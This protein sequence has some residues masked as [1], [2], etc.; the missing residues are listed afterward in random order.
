MPSTSD[1]SSPF[2]PTRLGP[3][4]ICIRPS[5]LRSIRM[6]ASTV[7]SRKTKMATALITMSQIGSCPNAERSVI[8]SARPIE[9]T[10]PAVTPSC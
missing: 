1:C 2:G 3:K 6:A 5:T 9:T 8:D 7:S 4:R 10:A